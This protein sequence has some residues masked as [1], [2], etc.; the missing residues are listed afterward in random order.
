MFLSWTYHMKHFKLDF[1]EKDDPAIAFER[2]C[3]KSIYIL[4]SEIHLFHNYQ[5]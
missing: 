5:N 4:V 1:C 3:E 2:T